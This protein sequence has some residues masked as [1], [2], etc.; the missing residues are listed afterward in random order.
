MVQTTI[1]NEE[2]IMEDFQAVVADMDQEQKN[3]YLDWLSVQTKY[4]KYE[5]TFKPQKLLNYRRRDLVF[6]NLG[7]NVNS[8]MGGKHW[9]V[10][11][12][13][14]NNRSSDSL[15]V[16]PLSSLNEDETETDVHKHDVYIGIIGEINNK[17][18][19]AR[20]SQIRTI[21]KMRI[22]KPKNKKQK[23]PRISE[24]SMN[25]IDMKILERYTGFKSQNI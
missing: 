13:H 16:I 14:R 9:A 4:L 6:I 21:S 17:E 11:I 23:R 12:D 10:V 22:Y 3:K 7:F 25:K 24:Q 8:E 1:P 18:V 15:V 2:Q 20:V 5:D 19:K